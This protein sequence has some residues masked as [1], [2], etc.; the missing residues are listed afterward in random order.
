MIG[1]FATGTMGFDTSHVSGRRRVP[2]PAAK[3]IALIGSPSRPV[4]AWAAGYI[5]AGDEPLKWSRKARSGV[6]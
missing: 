1:R 6:K 3:T 5:G 2:S 4:C